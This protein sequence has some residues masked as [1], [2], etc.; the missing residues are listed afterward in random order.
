MTGMILFSHIDN[1]P[2]SILLKLIIMNLMNLLVLDTGDA[3]CSEKLKLLLYPSHKQC[4]SVPVSIC[5]EPDLGYRKVPGA[6]WSM[7]V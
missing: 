4:W 5:A 1:N 6:M 3:I 2:G 7:R